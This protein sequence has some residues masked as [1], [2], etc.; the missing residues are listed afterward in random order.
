MWFVTLITASALAILL[1]GLAADLCALIL[2]RY[3]SLIAVSRKHTAGFLVLDAALASLFFLCALILMRAV[4]FASFS[5]RMNAFF[6]LR[7]VEPHSANSS[8]DPTIT[9]SSMALGVR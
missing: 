1:F 8:H 4:I 3:L 7:R 6:R 2:A 5:H 9:L